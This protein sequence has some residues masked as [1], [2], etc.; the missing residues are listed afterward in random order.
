MF[1]KMNHSYLYLI[2]ITIVLPFTVNAQGF[3]YHDF[4]DGDMGPFVKCTT[5]NPNYTKVVKNRLETYW[6]QTSYD[7][8]R[9][10]KG[11]E[12]CGDPDA[13]GARD[14]GYLTYKH[15]WAGFIMNIDTGYMAENPNSDGG[16]MQVFGFYQPDGV[17]KYSSW[18]AMLDYKKGNITWVDRRNLSTKTYALVYEDY[19]KGQDVAV[20]VHV[21]LSSNSNGMVEIFMDG[22]K[23]YSRYNINI[24]MGVFNDDDEQIAPDSYTELKIG[25]YDYRNEGGYDESY[26]GTEWYD[27]YLEGEERIVRYDNIGWYDGEDGYDIVN[28]VKDTVPPCGDPQVYETVETFTQQRA[29]FKYTL[30]VETSGTVNNGVIGLS[31]DTAADGFEDLAA[32][33]QFSDAG[34]IKVRN[35]AVY[36]ADEVLNW[37]SD[38][39]YD[40]VMTVNVPNKTYSVT[41]AE[42]GGTAIEIATDYSFRS[43]WVEAAY[44]D[45]AIVKTGNCPLLVTNS[46]MFEII[47]STVT[48]VEQSPFSSSNEKL[49]VYP[50]PVLNEFVIELADEEMTYYELI[51]VKGN[52]VYKAP[53]DSKTTT[54]DASDLKAGVYLVKVADD[55]KIIYKIEESNK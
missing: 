7:G 22:V 8:S 24:G 36:E 39:V 42:S 48:A 14:I 41:A 38:K 45:R 9:M 5:K 2:I 10:T 44:L 21:V 54:I 16:L 25:Q 4:D 35:G 17:D 27:G 15:V 11:A 34:T 23:R 1:K 46:S 43:D 19:P 40:I 55:S 53:I 50:N 12:A 51:D 30:E 6:T 32:I 49:K 31:A 47:D 29:E 28:P 3:K 33:V 37:A 20:I 52:T 18:T 13:E 26:N